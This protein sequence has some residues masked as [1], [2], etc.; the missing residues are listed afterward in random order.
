MVLGH[1]ENVSLIDFF[2][3]LFIAMLGAVDRS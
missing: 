3:D 1:D 2:M